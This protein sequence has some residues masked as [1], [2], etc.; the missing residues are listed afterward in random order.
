MSTNKVEI[1]VQPKPSHFVAFGFRFH[2]F[3]ASGYHRDMKRMDAFILLD[4]NSKYHFVLFENEGEELEI[5]TSQ[6]LIV[7][8][9]GGKPL[10][11]PNVVH[12]PFMMNIR[13]ECVKASEVLTVNPLG[14]LPV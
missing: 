9:I 10:C 1:L 8:I 13:E 14:T 11:N 6:A 7:L 2:N 5:V 3:I 12:G 4:D